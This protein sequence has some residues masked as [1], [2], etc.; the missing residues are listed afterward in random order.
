MTIVSPTSP[1]DELT[2]SGLPESD[3]RGRKREL[4][5]DPAVSREKLDRELNQYQRIA[6]DQ[7]AKGCFVLEA[8]YP[9]VLVAFAAAHLR[10]A[11]LVFGALLDFTNY[12]LWPPSVTL[13]NSFT[14]VPYL[15]RDLPPALTMT[16]RVKMV[17][18][19][20]I[21]G[22]GQMAGVTDQPLMQSYGPD[23]M[24]FFCIPG[25]REYHDHPA[26]SGDSWL[27]HR[28]KGEG[29]L[30]FIIDQLHRYGIQPLQGY[31]FGMQI[32]G[33]ARPVPPE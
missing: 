15:T 19:V 11:A 6:A 1:T 31:E 30:F 23:D 12:D 33:Y 5:V 9:E 3:I 2:G 8:G 25:V 14:R 17:M 32:V 20:M 22:L 10:P 16:R 7:R 21:P 13:V 18:P 27:A 4:L 26:H 28:A 29:T 24:P